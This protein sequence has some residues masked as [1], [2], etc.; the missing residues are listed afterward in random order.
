[1]ADVSLVV[2]GSAAVHLE[3]NRIY[4]IGNGTE[5]DISIAD[6]VR[7]NGIPFTIPG[8]NLLPFLQSIEMAHGV[9]CVL[10]RGFVRLMSVAGR[11][12][13]NGEEKEVTD[14]STFPQELRFG[15]VQARLVVKE[16]ADEA[17]ESSGFGECLKDRS[18]DTS[19]DSLLIPET[20]P[21]STN[22]SVNT[23]ADSFFVPETQAVFVNRPSTNGKISLGDDFVI[24]ETQDVLADLSDLEGPT[25]AP[26][27]VESFA[28]RE[29]SC[30]S[31][32]DSSETGTQIRICTQ[33]F[34]DFNEDAIDDFDASLILG[35]ALL[36]VKPIE[37]KKVPEKGEKRKDNLDAT[38]FEMSAFN[39]SASNP[40]CTALNSTKHQDVAPQRDACI[41]PDLTGDGVMCTPDLV[42]MIVAD[43]RSNTT[44]LLCGVKQLVVATIET[45]RATQ[46]DSDDTN[47]DL[48]ATQ[49]FLGNK[50]SESNTNQDLIATQRFPGNK[51]LETDSEDEDHL[52]K[53]DSSK[54]SNITNQDFIATQR[55]PGNKSL[56][57]DDPRSNLNKS[58]TNQDFIATQRFPGNKESPKN[59][60]LNQDFI[61]TQ[62]FPGKSI[63]S[64]CQ[65]FIA[66]QP[67][68]VAIKSSIGSSNKENIPARESASADEKEKE[69]P[70]KSPEGKTI[71]LKALSHLYG[72]WSSNWASNTLVDLNLSMEVWDEIDEVLKE[73]IAGGEM[74]PADPNEE[75][76]KFFKPCV[77]KDKHHNMKVCQIK[78]VFTDM[79]NKGRWNIENA[80]EG[81]RKRVARSESPPATRGP[82]A[83][84]KLI[85]SRSNTPTTEG[86]NKKTET[87]SGAKKTKPVEDESV[88]KK[89]PKP[90]KKPKHEDNSEDDEN[91][92]KQKAI[93]TR[94]SS[95]CNTPK[96]EEKKKSETKIGAK[97]AKH[98]DDE[99]IEKKNR[100]PRRK[101]KNEDAS[102]EE[103]NESPR[104]AIQ[105]RHKTVVDAT[106]SE[107]AHPVAKRR[108]RKK[109]EEAI[110]SD[111]STSK[112]PAKGKTGVAKGSALSTSKDSPSIPVTSK[113]NKKEVPLERIK[114]GEA[115]SKDSPSIPAKPAST[116]LK[117]KEEPDEST[118]NASVKG[119]KGRATSTDSPSDLEKPA[120]KK[121]KQD[122]VSVKSKKKDE[123]KDTDT[124]ESLGTAPAKRQPR[125]LKIPF[126]STSRE[127]PNITDKSETKP[128]TRNTR[129]KITN[130]SLTKDNVSIT[131]DSTTKKETPA[132]TKSTR[133]NTSTN[134]ST[135]KAKVEKN[136]EEQLNMKWPL[137]PVFNNYLLL[138]TAINQ[139]VKKAKVSGKIKIAFSMC[140]RQALESV[141]KALKNVVE[142]TENPLLCDLLLMDRGERT[143]KFL[144]SV[145][146]NKPIL[147]TSWLHSVR[148]NSSII[149]KTEHLFKDAKFEDTFRFQPILVLEHP[150]LLEGI[151]FMICEGIQP[152]PN[153]ISSILQ[154]AGAKVLLKP[155][156]LANTVDLYVVT[157]KNDTKSK[158]LLRSH[159]KVHFIK[160]E[161]IMQALVR[162]NVS[163]LDEYMLKF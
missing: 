132:K 151:H 21:P 104:Q 53:Q 16:D 48:I 54:K 125:D 70:K 158:R 3:L 133:H 80:A 43:E 14:I 10:R 71:F 12:F 62:V 145:A 1:M 155:P 156:P 61:E 154:S 162:H 85:K 113:S 20:Q 120:S 134:T 68:H 59:Q 159:E 150:R 7:L 5:V 39:W 74:S 122:Q 95:S 140:D 72:N 163:L 99:P 45:P 64:E 123:P 161:G 157:T 118:Y 105:T 36:A 13:T 51:I 63:P 31:D 60:S 109:N 83:R 65:D 130:E 137:V 79:N 26:P 34:N 33:D 55:F 135:A 44:P 93:Q 115:S 129:R 6:E 144:S 50:L 17:Q 102:D 141:L 23:T 128:S 2:Q 11:I 37:S 47:Q 112:A 35:D 25:G 160:T 89:K 84:K 143:Y 116:K 15:N 90:R 92:S 106:K 96:T 32:G 42:D 78:G 4:R 77:I 18:A 100:K 124:E 111:V 38:D 153:E 69:A 87:K 108:E 56:I 52:L 114:R 117:K 101:T 147:N 97:K 136:S 94:H 58:H 41:T 9:A 107:E 24:P 138:P 142:I 29:L 81:S 67:F 91:E 46:E 30:A 66:T 88:E 86:A 82:S 139:H 73:M 8:F 28:N 103:E 152:K 110:E 75:Q 22:T 119:Q 19:D 127:S 76:I 40:K 121:Q 27:V 131:K 98:G 57:S 146:S 49:R 149:V 148:A 126:L